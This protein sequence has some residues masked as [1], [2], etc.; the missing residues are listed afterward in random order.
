[1]VVQ[2][3]KYVSLCLLLLVCLFAAPEVSASYKVIDSAGLFFS[4]EI[5]QIEEL[6]K[7]I[8]TTYKMNVLVLTDQE[9]NGKSSYEKSDAAYI[10]EGYADDQANGGICLIIDMANREL[11]STIDRSMIRFINDS[12]EEKLYDTGYGYLS[13]GEYGD[14][15]IA[16]LE[17]VQEYMEKGIPGGQ[18]NY[19][20]E[21]GE[22]SRY[23]A[24]TLMD[25][26]IAAGGAVLLPLLVVLIVAS[27]Y[28]KV[29]KYRY[30]MNSNARIDITHSSDR[31]VKQYTT[32]RR[33]NTG[34]SG[35]SSGHSGSGRSTTHRSSGG[36]SFGGG[37]G[38]KF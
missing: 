32:K 19:D 10:A 30:D 20:S 15:I 27:G 9:R 7:E 31:F 3:K 13:N 5:A 6:A 33:I 24:V 38:R 17:K 23:Y 35:G 11:N 28:K 37:H 25:V 21:T 26:G 34:S 8:D 36:H 18:Y 22:I 14:A 16:M 29:K 4:S 2:M 12:R 1:M